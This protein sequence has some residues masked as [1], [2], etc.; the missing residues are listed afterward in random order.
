M[1]VIYRIDG[2]KRIIRT[3][4]IGQVTVDEVID[5]FRVLERDADCPERL[6]VLLDVSEATSIPLSENLR[7]VTQE[8]GRIRSR[9]QFDS[10]AIVACGDVLFG[11]MRMFEVFAEKYF[12]E[13]CA[14][15]AIGD[16]EAWLASRQQLDQR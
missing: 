8:I 10:C 16:A 13:T 2:T 12:R 6:D 15:R 1:P 9:V 14:F 3:R 5:H 11:M 4:C 7:Q